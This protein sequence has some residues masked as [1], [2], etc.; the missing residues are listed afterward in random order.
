M[1][2]ATRQLLKDLS[3]AAIPGMHALNPATGRPYS[4]VEYFPSKLLQREVNSPIVLLKL[5]GDCGG[6]VQKCAR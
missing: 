2:D 5:E 3:N 6:E 1:A 4:V